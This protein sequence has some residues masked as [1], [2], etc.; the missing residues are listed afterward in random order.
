MLPKRGFPRVLLGPV[1][2][3]LKTGTSGSLHVPCKTR[4]CLAIEHLAHWGQWAPDFVGR[5]I[6][7]NMSP[8]RRCRLAQPVR[9]NERA[10]SRHSERS[11]GYRARPSGTQSGPSLC[12]GTY[13]ALLARWTA[14]YSPSYFTIIPASGLYA[15]TD[16]LVEPPSSRTVYITRSNRLINCAIPRFL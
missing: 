4:A 9:P 3:P 7:V 13:T 16:H 14:S 1:G 12:H 15:P 8:T 2:L 6:V 11:D 5:G 10:W